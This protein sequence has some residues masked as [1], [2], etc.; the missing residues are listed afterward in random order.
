[1]DD[2][3]ETLI[4]SVLTATEA[5]PRG[6]RPSP[7]YLIILSG[8]TPGSM[9]RLAPG[10]TR[11]G[12]ATENPVQLAEATVS[13]VHAQIREEHGRA[14]LTDLG[15][16]NGTYVNNER[17]HPYEV[18]FIRDGDRIQLGSSVNFKF[19]RPDPCEEHFQRVM[20]ERSVRDPLTGLFNRKYFLEQADAILARGMTQG[21]SIAVLMLDID[22]FKRINDT[23]GH[24]VGDDVLREVAAVL[25]HSTRVDD[26]V[27]R[28]GGEE[29]VAILPVAAPDQ[30]TERAERI[31]RNLASRRIVSGHL[32]VR[33]TA[34]I[35][36]AIAPAGHPRPAAKLISVAD[37]SLYQ[38]KRTGRDRVVCSSEATVCL[39]QCD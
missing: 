35:G 14:W 18:T 39:T 11:I 22:H 38:A 13:R 30:A 32:L 20:F 37:D 6:R 23:H 5:G 29:F 28:Y 25:R 15:S 34:S 4:G 31:R 9:F 19:L 8:G 26:L 36:L 1:M 24:E 10:V 12:R 16:T 7:T 21:L 27:A 17:L 33:I 3:G 2:K